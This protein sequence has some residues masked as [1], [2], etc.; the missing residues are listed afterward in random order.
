MSLIPAQCLIAASRLA[1]LRASPKLL[2]G[3]CCLQLAVLIFGML[4]QIGSVECAIAV[5]TSGPVEIDCDSCHRRTVTLRSAVL[6]AGGAAVI[7]CG[8]FAVKLREPKM[9]YI[10]GTAMLFFALV[11]GLTAML[12]SLE[13]P[14]LEMAVSGVSRFDQDC[15]AL[16]DEMLTSARDH[17]TL[18]SLGCIVDTL[19]AVLAIR[20][21][22]LFTY[23]DIASQHAEVTAAQPL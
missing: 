10:Y 15:S 1:S 12:T 18:A 16:A 22:E 13:A 11:I 17:T 2:V 14:V 20:S 3:V 6:H 8:L 4:Q 23:E 21:R 7:A 5:P 9:L 19:G